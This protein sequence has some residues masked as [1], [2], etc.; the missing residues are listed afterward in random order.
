[1][2]THVSPEWVDEQ[3]AVIIGLV[4]TSLRD[5]IEAV[6]SVDLAAARRAIE[7]DDEIDRRCLTLDRDAEILLVGRV[8]SPRDMGL[9]LASTR[10]GRNLERMADQCVTIGKLVLGGNDDGPASDDV[11]DLLRDMGQRGERML[12]VAADCLA[13]R[14]PQRALE[15]V[16]LDKLVDELN[17]VL[18]ERVLDLGGERARRD[19]GLRMVLAARAFERIAD[20]AVDIGEQAA[21]IA[22]GELREFTDASHPEREPGSA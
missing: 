10:V 13:R 20:N 3:L 1:V 22:T 14:D 7:A 2:A 11:R 5:A 18:I 8:V 21:Y 17:R 9:M 6:G 4:R 15:L 16:E 12:E 19:W